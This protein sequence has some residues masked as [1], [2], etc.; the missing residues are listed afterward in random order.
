MTLPR[1]QRRLLQSIGEQL[2]GE[3]PQLAQQL[4]EFEELSCLAP[5]P[6]SEHLPD[7][8]GRFWFALSAAL[9]AGAWLIPDQCV[10]ANPARPAGGQRRVRE[11]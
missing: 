7:D 4:K 2:S 5:M 6:A 10:A 8:I 3:D 9:G 1:R 11:P